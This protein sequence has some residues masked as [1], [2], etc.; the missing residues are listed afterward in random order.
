MEGNPLRDNRLNRLR[1]RYKLVLLPLC[2]SM[3]L[4]SNAIN[5][6]LKGQWSLLLSKN[7]TQLGLEKCGPLGEVTFDM[8]ARISSP[9]LSVWIQRG[10]EED[11]LPTRQLLLFYS[12]L[13][14]WV[15]S[16]EWAIIMKKKSC[17]ILFCTHT[18]CLLQ[19]W[20]RHSTTKFLPEKNQVLNIVRRHYKGFRI[21]N[22]IER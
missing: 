8:C 22:L 14:L 19:E 11:R 16:E 10:K 18:I 6:A 21:Q 7:K 5:A 13:F 17:L 3:A 20:Q 12:F 1:Q 9:G 4:S 2:M 15:K